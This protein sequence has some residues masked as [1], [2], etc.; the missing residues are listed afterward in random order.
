MSILE[1]GSVEED[2]RGTTMRANGSEAIRDSVDFGK[3]VV[4]V[5]EVGSKRSGSAT[6]ACRVS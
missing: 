4:E 2:S 6:L 5:P 1:E 3:L